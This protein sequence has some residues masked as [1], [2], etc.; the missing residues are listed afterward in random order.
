MDASGLSKEELVRHIESMN[1]EMI[2]LQAALREAKGQS[3]WM[4]DAM[5]ARTRVL[6]ERMKELDCVYH[7]VR[8]LRDPDL[9][10]EQRIGRIVDL[11][12]KAW[13]R[14]D[15]ACARAVLG[16]REFRTGRFAPGPWALKTPITVKGQEVGSLEV[17]YLSA[18]PAMDEG[19]FLR[20]ERELL[21]VVAEC[22]GAAY[23]LDAA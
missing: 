6:N 7:A 2:E 4:G 5:K 10:L 11:L 18:S 19:P 20:E 15:I 16:E 1:A 14:P 9:R 17:V 23:E 8:I 13:L 21:R 12:P 22:L 3:D